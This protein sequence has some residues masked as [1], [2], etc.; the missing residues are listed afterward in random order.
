ML[1]QHRESLQL[2]HID[3]EEKELLLEQ[4][5]PSERLQRLEQRKRLL[6]SQTQSQQQHE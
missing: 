1:G 6:E 4:V 3:Q 5:A 2:R